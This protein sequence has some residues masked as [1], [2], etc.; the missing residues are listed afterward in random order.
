MNGFEGIAYV[1]SVPLIVVVPADGAKSIAELA[2]M[3]RKEKGNTL[4]RR[5]ATAA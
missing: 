3:L 5:P 2:D 4:T 1:A